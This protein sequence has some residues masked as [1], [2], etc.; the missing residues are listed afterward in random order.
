MI[1]IS[2]EKSKKKKAGFLEF[3][4]KAL[5]AM[6]IMWFLGALLGFVVVGIQICRNDV[7]V[8]LSDILL[9]IGAPMT[10]GIVAYMIKSAQENTEK[11][12]RGSS[13]GDVNRMEQA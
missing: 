13:D 1:K 10:G 12:K 7:M 6:I 11:I 8:N 9:Y 5:T 2:F 3:S 4:K